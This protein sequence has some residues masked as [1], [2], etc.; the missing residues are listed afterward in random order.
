MHSGSGPTTNMENEAHLVFARARRS[1][2]QIDHSAFH[3]R[4]DGR[5][6]SLL[7]GRSHTDVHTAESCG[8]CNRRGS[9]RAD[10]NPKHVSFQLRRWSQWVDATRTCPF[11]YERRQGKRR[12]GGPR[13]TSHRRS[14]ASNGL[15]YESEERASASRQGCFVK[16]ASRRKQ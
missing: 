13:E 14:F 6:N 16:V 5:K 1:H 15:W 2:D 3:G 11:P 8:R 7:C 4:T 9:T 12:L 10:L